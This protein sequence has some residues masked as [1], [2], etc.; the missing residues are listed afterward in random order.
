ITIALKS[1]ERFFSAELHRLRGEVLLQIGGDG[2]CELQHALAVARQQQA[3]L[4]ELRV[5][6]SLARLRRDQDRRAEAHG[7]LAPV[8]GWFTEGF[9][10]P[11]LKDAKALLKA[12]EA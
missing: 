8:C 5:A 12:L 11:D 2:E 1:E 7:L 4:W 9:G 6:L 3:K 10:T